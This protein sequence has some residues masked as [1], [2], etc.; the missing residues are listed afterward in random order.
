MLTA[1]EVSAA[2]QQVSAAAMSDAD[3][4]GFALVVGLVLLWLWVKD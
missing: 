3:W 4:K 1:A 2:A